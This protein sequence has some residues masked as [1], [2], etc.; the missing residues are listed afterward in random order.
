MT[1]SFLPLSPPPEIKA[2]MGLISL[3]ACQLLYFYSV[4]LIMFSVMASK[5]CDLVTYL[6]CSL[7]QSVSNSL[8][9]FYSPARSK[10]LPTRLK[11]VATMHI[12]KSISSTPG[13][14]LAA[15]CQEVCPLPKSNQYFLFLSPQNSITGFWISLCK[16]VSYSRYFLSLASFTQTYICKTH[17]CYIQN[18]FIFIVAEKYSVVGISHILFIH[19]TMLGLS[20]CS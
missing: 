3:R 4:S 9:A 11:S 19:S 15:P 1:D 13:A 16:W 5:I 20:S 12:N 18:Q 8:M 7:H 10:S 17:P 2:A 14:F 6:A